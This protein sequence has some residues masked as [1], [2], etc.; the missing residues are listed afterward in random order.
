M[1]RSIINKYAVVKCLNLERKC[2]IMNCKDE[3][4]NKLNNI[5]R[6][7]KDQLN[8]MRIPSFPVKPQDISFLKT[9]TEYYE[10]LLES[11]QS[12]KNLIS[13]SS[14]YIGDGEM[15]KQLI[16]EI[17]IRIYNCPELQVNIVLDG[18]RGTRDKQV[19]NMLRQLSSIHSSRVTVSYIEWLFPLS[20]KKIIPSRYNESFALNHSKLFIWDDNVMVTGANLSDAYFINRVDRY[21]IVKNQQ[22]AMYYH[23]FIS[24]LSRMSKH[25]TLKERKT[26]LL[27]WMNSY[28]NPNI[29]LSDTVLYP[30][31]QFPLLGFRQDELLT[32]SILQWA[33][34]SGMDMDIATAYFNPA[35]TYERI[36]IRGYHS[37]VW[38]T[39]SINNEIDLL[40]PKTNDIQSSNLLKPGNNHGNGSVRI[41]TSSPQCNAFYK[42]QGLSKWIPYI[43][44]Q[45]LRRWELLS[46]P[47]YKL[48]EYDKS[49]EW[50]FHA[51]GLWIRYSKDGLPWI[52]QIGSSNY[53]ARSIHRDVETSLT[54]TTTNNELCKKL[55][56]V[57]IEILL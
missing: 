44:I 29:P 17:E 43:Y 6:S 28:Q 53:G 27:E 55:E 13:I 14:L 7:W 32:S 38:K 56:Q 22:L 15:E 54:I 20:L 11:I 10:Q 25:G 52:S 57:N 48:L 1:N 3:H 35:S 36:L 37:F 5:F 39:T 46:P 45:F 4:E 51:K 42:G 24:L 50:T 8:S 34:R 33:N 9:P 47:H 12:A 16:K 41:I 30:S 26:L 31:I 40:F 21:V 2:T 49:N 18:M 23:S 19:V